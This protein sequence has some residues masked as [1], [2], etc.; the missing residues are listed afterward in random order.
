MLNSVL[1]QIDEPSKVVLVGLES[2]GKSA[3]FRGLSGRDTGEEANFRGSTVTV[4]RTVLPEYEHELI[5]TPGIRL[6]DDSVTTMLALRQLAEADTIVLV[7]RAPSVKTDLPLLLDM[8]DIAGINVV[9]VLTFVDKCG[10]G[11][12]DQ[13]SYYRKGLGVS[14]LPVNAKLI[15]DDSREL[16][17]RAIAAARPMKRTP[18]IQ[19]P[20]PSAVIEP[21][22]TVFEHS[23]WG[24]LWAL[25]AL[26]LLFAVPVYVAYLFSNWMQP[27]AEDW[28]VEP[29]RGAISGLWSPFQSIFLGDYGI[30][31]LGLYSFIWA[32]PVVFLIGV[33]VAVTE[34]SG[35]KD[36][37]TDSLDGWMRKIGLNGK[38]LIPVLSGFGCNVVAVFQ[39]RTCS[40]C[41]RRTCVSMI[42]FGSACSYQIGASLS[43]F[44]SG[45]KPWLFFPYML[46]L[47]LVGA[48]HTRLWNRKQLE[49][50]GPLLANRTFLQK[51]SWRS[52]SW[53]VK[54]I[55]KQF[56]TQAMPIFIGICIVATLLEQTG[57]LSVLTRALAPALTLVH[58]PA[59]A[60]G[61]ILFSILRKDGLLVLNQDQGSF[62]TGLSGE[63][64][65]ILV[66][67]ASTLT[68]CLVTLWTVRKELGA[69]F[70]LT[71]ASKQLLTSIGSA[72]LLTWFWQG[73][74]MTIY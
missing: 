70:A 34:E 60:A 59:E 33:S 74:L 64:L 30:F 45:G 28:I 40:S 3:L 24:R 35:L 15:Q 41:T 44:S 58:L 48:L 6:K 69:F 29:L 62:I 47:V 32:F 8:L 4:R 22:V 27:Y 17:F 37:I 9:L 36:R 16:L 65:F 13:V 73:I 55:M 72:L 68:A 12:M 53:R 1:Q 54:S 71:M 63:Q 56:L 18:E 51:P 67:L 38:D 7:I 11:L 10:P 20:P 21:A 39:S 14:V 49:P 43:I 25:A 5:D 31:S 19:S 52:I 46:V 2:A 23:I 26:V 61:G 57:I 66:Y 42:A 50:T